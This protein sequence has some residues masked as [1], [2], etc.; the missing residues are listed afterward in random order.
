[1]KNEYKNV[2][3]TDHALQRLKRRRISQ[4]MAVQALRHPDR[5]QPEDDDKIRFIKSIKDRNVQVVAR[6]LSDEGQW[7]VVTAWV[8]GEEDPRRWWLHVLLLPW[9]VLRVVWRVVRAIVRGL[10]ARNA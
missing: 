10:R 6:H 8:R 3:F 4:A 7:M 2:I 5:Q 1:M 9:Y